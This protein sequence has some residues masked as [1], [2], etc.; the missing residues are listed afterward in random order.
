MQ[1]FGGKLKVLDTETLEVK[2][3]SEN[4]FYPVAWSENGQTIA[5]TITSFDPEISKNVSTIQ[6]QSFDNDLIHTVPLKPLDI[7]TNVEWYSENQIIFDGRQLP[8]DKSSGTGLLFQEYALN[9][10]TTDTDTY[11]TELLLSDEQLAYDNPQ[12]SPNK[13]FLAVDVHDVSG[14]P[15]TSLRVFDIK[16][17]NLVVEL[18]GKRDLFTWTW[19][20]NNEEILVRMSNFGEG[21]FGTLS[22]TSGEF[23]PIPWPSSLE[24]YILSDELWINQ[25]NFVW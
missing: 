1:T 9:I 23:L 14:G 24:Q 3:L 21:D 18:P 2:P 10:Y 16:N 13:Q 11:E 19:G 5:T 4:S 6:L 17:K 15:I 12:L 25:G 7:V 20:P 8:D 22:L